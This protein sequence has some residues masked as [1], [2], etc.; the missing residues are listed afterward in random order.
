MLDE[1]EILQDETEFDQRKLIISEGQSPIRLDQFLSDKLAQVSRNKIQNSIS[2]ELI[3]VNGRAIKSNYKIRPNDII[4]IVFP[5]SNIPDK[6]IPQE[7]PLEIIYEDEHLLVINK[8][9][10]MVVHPAP[11]NY[12]GTLANALAFYLKTGTQKLDNERLGLVH[13]IDKETS[14]LLLVA[15][16]DKAASHLSSQFFHHSI[17]RE[18]ITLVWGSP[19][20]ESGTITG[21]IARDPRNR[22]RMCIVDDAESGKHAITHYEVI[23]SFYYTS[24]IKCKLETGRTHQIRVHMKSIGHPL[25]NDERYDGDKIWKGTIFSK[26]KQFVQ[27]CYKLVPRFA[28]HARSLGF[29]HP[30]SHKK[31]YFEVNPP[32]DFYELV[33]K[34][35]KYLSIRKENE[36]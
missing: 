23:E 26:Y 12:E 5:K 10:G 18:Y 3:K 11:G 4:D 32:D 28:L 29:I 35:R 15:K 6:V 34:W 30:E 31:M 14:G 21:N 20:L 36:S 22:Q 33:D 9:P 8:Q 25:F 1:H 19:D 2:A 13:R 16:T 7:I 24:L 17:E 27:N